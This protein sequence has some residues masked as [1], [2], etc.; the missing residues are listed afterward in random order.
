M[1]DLFRDLNKLRPLLSRKD[2]W[3]FAILFGLMLLASLLE[4]AGIGAIPLFVSLVMKPSSLAETPVIGNW[5]SNLPNE[6]SISIVF[7]A[8]A[9]LL[10][11]IIIKNLFLSFAFYMQA[12]LVTSQRVKI[13]DRLFRAYQSAPYEWHLQRS[14]SELLRNLQ[15]DTTE[16]L[17]S[18]L[19]PFLDLVMAII[20][21]VVIIA[22]LTLTTP[23]PALL[24]M[25]STAIGLYIVIRL[26]HKRLRR[27]GETLR[28]GY[29]EMVKAVQQ[30]FGALVD[31]RIMG[32]ESHLNKVYKDSLIRQARAKALRITIEKSSPYA[33]EAFAIFGLLLILFILI[34]TADSLE[35]ILP[36][37]FLLGVA[38][39]RLKQLASGI[40]SAIN[41][42][43]TGRVFIPGIVN[44]LSELAAVENKRLSRITGSH[45]I[46]DFR[47]LKLENVTYAYPDTESN[48]VKDISLE[49]NR[50]ESIG[51]VGSTGCGK[52]TLVNLILGLLEPKSGHILVNGIDTYQDIMGWRAN[53]GYI[54]QSIYLLDDTITANVAFGVPHNEVDE[55]R[56]WF[57]LRSA[58]LEE[59][60]HSLPQGLD[61][62]IGERGVRLSG[63]QRQRLGIARALYPNPEVL[64]M[65]E[66][67]SALDHKTEAEVM[68]AI[69]NL[70]QDRTLI[71]IA[72]RLS[73]VEDCDRLYFLREGQI[74]NYGAYEELKRSSLSF[75][76]MTT[77]KTVRT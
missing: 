29:L 1:L 7:W 55:K 31:A 71:M 21:A 61:T 35:A 15:S 37:I 16:V 27:V 76:D 39:L 10:G 74:E 62:I 22:M 6:P 66:A 47:T 56:L 54:P 67:T 12:R 57:A 33:I 38:T 18:V 73:T 68:L 11:F 13:S 52:S 51:F 69:Q 30:G 72:H 77:D 14:S 26:F 43:N 40:A 34:K 25:I 19:M 58:R 64:I 70:K 50:G 42:M 24:G 49:L 23:G 36:I 28:G 41:K 60:I 2:K 44:D 53:L 65:D 17:Y 3:K 9:A 75:L 20:M 59:F 63:G 8:S 32:C 48:A 46:D 45:K 4:A 5:F